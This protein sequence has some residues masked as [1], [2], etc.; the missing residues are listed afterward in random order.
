MG[1]GNAAVFSAVL[2]RRLFPVPP[3]TREKTADVVAGGL[4]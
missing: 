2:P 3:H 4:T 1:N